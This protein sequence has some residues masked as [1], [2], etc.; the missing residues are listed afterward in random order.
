MIFMRTA[1]EVLARTKTQTSRLV[2]IEDEALWSNPSGNYH[3][4]HAMAGD[5]VIDEVLRRGRRLYQ[6]GGT[7][8][9]QPGRTEPSVGRIRLLSIARRRLQTLTAEEHIA[10]G[11]RTQFG[12]H[13]AVVDLRD[14]FISLWNSVY[15]RPA[16][17][18]EADPEIWMLTFKLVKRDGLWLP[19]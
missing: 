15:I 18:W 2:G 10:E 6:V 3:A 11:L 1:D 7:Y 4:A 13:D 17:R 16:H 12:G 9:V 19:S 5:W 14:Q 8:A